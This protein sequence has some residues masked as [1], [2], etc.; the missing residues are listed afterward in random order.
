M[1]TPTDEPGFLLRMIFDKLDGIDRKL[2][3]HAE[4]L[5]SQRVEISNLRSR[6]DS[7]ENDTRAKDSARRALWTAVLTALVSAALTIAQLVYR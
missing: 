7:I 2:D 1:T 6:L 3:G 5:A 4:D